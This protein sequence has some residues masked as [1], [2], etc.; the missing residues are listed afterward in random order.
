MS[1]GGSGGDSGSGGDTVTGGT[2]GTS[3][4]GGGSGTAG[5]GGSAGSNPATSVAFAIDTTAGG[6]A[7]SPLIYGINP[8][9]VACS[10]GSARFTLCRLGGD[11]WSTYNWENNASNAGA[12]LCFQNDGAL[13]ASDEP[14]EAVLDLLSEADASGAATLVTV[15]LLDYVAADKLGG[16]PPDECSGDVRKSGSDYL[17]TRFKTSA[18]RKGAPFVTPPDTTDGAV[19][20]DEFVAFV[21]AAASSSANVLFALDNQPSLWGITQEAVHPEHPT[22]AEV[23][24]RN[25][26]YAKMLRDQW[27]AAPIAGYVGYGWLDFV[28]LQ[29]APDADTLG[30][31][32]DYYLAGMADASATDTRRLIDYLDVHWFPEVYAGDPP[33]RI[34]DNVATPAAVAA[35]VQNPRSLWDST[36]AE[37]SWIAGGQALRLIPWLQERIAAKYPGTKLAISEWNYGGGADVS[38]AIAA[39]DALGVFGREDVGFAAWKS[40]EHDDPFVVGAFRMFRNYDGAGA[41]FGDISLPATSS[42]IDLASVYASADSNVPGRVVIVAINRADH[43]VDAALS[44]DASISLTTAATYVLTSASP[45]PTAGAV[46][47]ATSPNAFSYTMPAYSVSV[48][49]PAP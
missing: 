35:R 31:F 21:K 15:P 1:T 13:A 46:L 2:G 30:L 19:Y 45:A 32:V 41:A 34:I 20:Q 7:I 18:A 38:G 10:N 28:N 44:I 36:F 27:P 39:A 49:V 40:I 26:A 9:S 4:L 25:V 5:A 48:I 6:H 47:A 11:R 43:A 3:A 37:D 14:G 33:T 17:D 23:V 8:E 29:Y 24:D 22:Y 16:T 12:P 42:A